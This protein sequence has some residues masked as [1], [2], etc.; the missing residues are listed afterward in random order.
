MNY[1]R[2]KAI[3]NGVVKY[4][5][6]EC[7]EFK[8]ASEYYGETKGYHICKSCVSKKNYKDT[9]LRKSPEKMTALENKI[10][11]QETINQLKRNKEMAV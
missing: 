10:R 7:Q 4:R 8:P 3:I 1:K 2:E 9:L 11:I 6:K 5:C